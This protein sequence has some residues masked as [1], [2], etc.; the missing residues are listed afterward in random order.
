MSAA[1]LAREARQAAIA[2]GSNV[3]A[4][5]EHLAHALRRLSEAEGTRLVRAS[6]W[7]ETEPVGGPSGQG[8]YLNGAC[9]VETTLEPRALLALLHEI[10]RE[11]GRE[12][13]REERNGPRTLDLD[14]ILC[15]DL[16]VSEA[17]LQVPHPRWRE[18]AFVLEPLAQVAPDLRDPLDGA[19]V[20][21]LRDHRALMERR[22]FP[23]IVACE[24][25]A[26]AREWLASARRGGGAPG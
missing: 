10:E 26:A 15:G 9:L 21:E 4:R 16:V 14:L 5:E 19:S 22:G 23:R 17:D 3:G 24:S 8:R 25:V 7:I 20:A 1:A 18:R 13:A 11:R 2:L 12:R 6:S